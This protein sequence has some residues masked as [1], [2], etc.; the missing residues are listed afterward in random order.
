M[1]DESLKSA[2]TRAR[3]IKLISPNADSV[4]ASDLTIEP[5]FNVDE[6]NAVVSMA[7]GENLLLLLRHCLAKRYGDANQVPNDRNVGNVDQQIL[8]TRLMLN[9]TQEITNILMGT[10]LRFR[11]YK[12]VPLSVALHGDAQ[13]R[14]STDVD[15]L[16]A[17]DD[18]QVAVAALSRNGYTTSIDASN[19]A[20][21]SFRWL[22]REIPLSSFGGL[23]TIDLHWRLVNFWNLPCPITHEEMFSS[24]G[25]TITIANQTLEW[26]TSSQLFRIQLAHAISSDW[27]GLKTFVDLAHAGS[28][29]GLDDWRDVENHCERLRSADALIVSANVL[30]SVFG[31]PVPTLSAEL[32]LG[33]IKRYRLRMAAQVCAQLLNLTSTATQNRGIF[34]MSLLMVNGPTSAARLVLRCFAPGAADYITVADRMHWGAP[35]LAAL[36]RR[37]TKYLDIA[38]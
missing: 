38:R 31:V 5:L 18:V 30:R 23:L 15:V 1:T 27:V 36:L 20:R 2:A 11:I 7:T 17:P 22:L 29:L 13:A 25:S 14:E 12:G 32:H 24:P 10:Q 37:V 19:F 6:W 8:S 9:L 34:Y 35:V 26:F 33:P 16:V 4:G 28:A 21:A 3:L